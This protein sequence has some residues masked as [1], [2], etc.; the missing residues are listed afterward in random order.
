MPR[1]SGVNFDST[2]LKANVEKFNDKVN[3]GVAAAFEYQAPKSAG[4]MKSEAPW[5]DQTGNARSGLFTAT[6]HTGTSHSM[7]LS[8]GVAYGIYLERKHSGRYAIVVPEIPRAGQDI[9]RLISKII[10]TIPGG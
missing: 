1:N 6:K 3:R 5:T 4:R 8:H 10:K 2:R 9:M 7:L